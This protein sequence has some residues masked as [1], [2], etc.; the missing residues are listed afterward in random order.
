MMHVMTKEISVQLDFCIKITTSLFSHLLVIREG[1]V[2]FFVRLAFCDHLSGTTHPKLNKDLTMG[3]CASGGWITVKDQ[4]LE[5]ANKF[6]LSHHACGFFCF[7]DQTPL[8]PNLREIS[9]DWIAERRKRLSKSFVTLVFSFSVFFA[10]LHQKQNAFLHWR[11]YARMIIFVSRWWW[12][13]WTA[14]VLCFKCRVA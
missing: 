7:G 13:Q 1:V 12:W 8:L 14:E 2:F 10:A 3:L 9:K 11:C 4:Q 6:T 5:L